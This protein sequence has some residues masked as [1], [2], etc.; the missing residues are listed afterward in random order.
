VL[1]FSSLGKKNRHLYSAIMV[2]AIQILILAVAVC[3]IQSLPQS[4]KTREAAEIL[5][6]EIE[7]EIKELPEQIKNEAIEMST[8]EIKREINELAIDKEAHEMEEQL[9]S[10]ECS[11]KNP[12][13]CCKH[14]HLCP[15][16]SGCTDEKDFGCQFCQLC[17]LCSGPRSVC[18][19]QQQ[20]GKR[21]I[22]MSTSE[23]KRE[24]NEL[25]RKIKNGD[26]AD[27]E[28]DQEERADEEEANGEDKPELYE[29]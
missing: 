11:P 27:E 10:Q 23:I 18:G 16:C 25:A 26:R 1:L 8:S 21:A 17:H 6:S 12:T 19:S 2:S 13:P 5:D 4:I 28:E 14:C 3:G 29:V 22:E 7:K 15:L 24:I 9:E 20:P